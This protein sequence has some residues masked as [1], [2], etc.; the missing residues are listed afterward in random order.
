LSAECEIDGAVY[1]TVFWTADEQEAERRMM[2]TQGLKMS[3]AL[4]RTC[5]KSVSRL[6]WWFWR[7]KLEINDGSG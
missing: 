4:P 1:A 3:A 2:P 6:E 7:K 5:G